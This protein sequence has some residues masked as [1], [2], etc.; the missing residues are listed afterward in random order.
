MSSNNLYSIKEICINVSNRRKRGV[1]MP[2]SIT[3]KVN[4]YSRMLV[5]TEYFA[6]AFDED[7]GDIIKSLIL[8]HINQSP[9]V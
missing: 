5:A 7:T 9:G 1:Y 4:K 6:Q 3:E 2:P 8:N